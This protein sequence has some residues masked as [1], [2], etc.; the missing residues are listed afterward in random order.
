MLALYDGAPRTVGELGLE[1]GMD[2]GTLTLLLKRLQSA[3]LVTRHW[4]QL[5]E[6]YLG[7][8]TVV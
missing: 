2:N 1:L 7:R 6:R 4:C 8:F 3:G 5:K